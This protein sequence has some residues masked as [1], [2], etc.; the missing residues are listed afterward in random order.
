MIPS[1]LS[2]IFDLFI[3]DFIQ[4]GSRFYIP[5]L[6]LACFLT[7]WAYRGQELQKTL[8]ELFNRDIWWSKS[9]RLDY[10]L[11]FTLSILLGIWPLV[12]GAIQIPIVH[13]IR[14]TL[15]QQSGYFNA[16]SWPSWTIMALYTFILFIVADFTQFIVHVAFHKIPFL[17]EFHKLHHTATTL[18][19]FTVYRFHPVEI[20]TGK[21]CVLV[22]ISTVTGVFVHLFG[23]RISI[24]L[25][26]G[27]PIINFCLDSF[28]GVLRHTIVP[29]RY[30]ELIEKII[31]SPRQHQL[32]HSRV[33]K[34]FDKNFGNGLAVWDLIFGSLIHS[35]K[36]NDPLNYGVIEDGKLIEDHGFISN[37]FIN[38][39]RVLFTKAIGRLKSLLIKAL[40]KLK[41]FNILKSTH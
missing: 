16:D 39:F 10:K 26:M 11:F 30:P 21:F 34:H 40:N 5:A 4:P 9:V 29:F 24:F 13:T 3:V 2:D 8:N 14:D 27:A 6:L 7:F 35:P 23:G 31:I 1:D 33:H 15:L 18:N 28:G 17:W 41:S 37:L 32:H 20:F 12:V 19:P 22:S 25:V 36:T 38:P